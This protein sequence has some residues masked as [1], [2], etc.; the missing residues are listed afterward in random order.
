MLFV[1]GPVPN[2]R[3][4]KNGLPIE[5]QPYEDGILLDSLRGHYFYAVIRPEKLT[6]LIEEGGLSVS[7]LSLNE[8]SVLVWGQN[9]GC[10]K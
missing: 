5:S 6:D 9:G 3:T 8:R 10:A 4:Q 1:R 7:G 2:L